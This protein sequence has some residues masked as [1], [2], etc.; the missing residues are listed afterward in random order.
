METPRKSKDQRPDKP[1]F[2]EPGRHRPI[3]EPDVAP[4]PD[5]AKAR[6][7]DKSSDTP[8]RTH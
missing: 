4:T 1:R 6:G 8:D 5:I 3:R 7:R 2:R